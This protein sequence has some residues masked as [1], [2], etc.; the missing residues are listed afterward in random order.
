MK[1]MFLIQYSSGQWEDYYT[2]N[3]FVTEDEELAKSYVNKFR[4]KLKKWKDYYNSKDSIRDK[5]YDRY[6]QIM[7]TNNAYYLKIEIR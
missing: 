3:V 6:C 7:E 2:V 5:H 4:A 1:E